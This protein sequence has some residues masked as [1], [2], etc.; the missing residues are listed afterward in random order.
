VS[1]LGERYGSF[2]G[3]TTVPA[4]QSDA[5][6]RSLEAA[7][8]EF[9]HLTKL[10]DRSLTEIETR[11]AL[12]LGQPILAYLRDPYFSETVSSDK[13]REFKAESPTHEEKLKQL[14]DEV[15]AL[16]GDGDSDGRGG[17]GGDIQPVALRHYLRPE[18]IGELVFEDIKRIIEEKYPAG[19]ELEPF[20]RERL[21]H[22]TRGRS[23]VN[24]SY[25]VSE[26][27]FLAIDTHVLG[28]D[29]R[30]DDDDGGGDADG[31]GRLSGSSSSSS[32][33][34]S[35]DRYADN[36]SE[37]SAFSESS[38]GA[39]EDAI[40]EREG[41]T[42]PLLVRG[43]PGCGKSALL[44]NWF[45]RYKGHR[46][47]DVVVA[48]WVGCSPAST[49]AG[50]IVA[51]LIREIREG[52]GAEHRDDARVPSLAEF[53][54]EELAAINPQRRR[55]VIV[56]DGLDRIDPRDD[57]MDLVWLPRFFPRSVRAVVSAGPSRALDV[58]AKRVAGS[59]GG[60][61]DSSG[62]GGGGGIG[63]GAEAATPSPPS[64]SSLTV[65]PLTPPHRRALLQTYLSQ[66]SKRLPPPTEFL[67][68]KAEQT[69]NPRYLVTL[70]DETILLGD[71]ASLTSTVA[72]YLEAQTTSELYAKVLKRMESDYDK[73]PAPPI[74]SLILTSLLTSRVGLHPS[75]ELRPLLERAGAGAGEGNWSDFLTVLESHGM[76][77]GFGQR[78]VLANEALREGVG[79]AFLSWTTASK[80]SGGGGGG[81]GG[82]SGSSVATS[83]SHADSVFTLCED[84]VITAAES[85][86]HAR[87]ADLFEGNEGEITRRKIEELPWHLELCGDASRLAGWLSSLAVF[88][89]MWTMGY[90]YDLQRYWRAIDKLIDQCRGIGGPPPSGA[91]NM[92]NVLRSDEQYLALV[93][94]SR[95]PPGVVVSDLLTRLAE[96]MAESSLFEASLGLFARA[97]VHYQNA[98]L[99]LGVAQ[100][101]TRVA[102]VLS[103]L[104][105]FDDAEAALRRSLAVYIKETGDEGIEVGRIF[106]SLG[107]VLSKSAAG[108]SANLAPARLQEARTCLDKSLEI[109]VARLGS[110]AEETADVLLAMGEL[111][112]M[113]NY[114]DVAL[115]RFKLA[116]AG[117]E[118]RLGDAHPRLVPTL[119]RLG[120]LYIELDEFETAESTLHTALAIATE[121]LGAQSRLTGEVLQTLA[122]LYE[123]QE[124]YSEA[125]AL[126]TRTLAIVQRVYGPQ[127]LHAGRMLLQ[128]GVVE[129]EL[130]RRSEGFVKLPTTSSAWAYVA[131][132]LHDT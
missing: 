88:D 66:R 11:T 98:F 22:A 27:L 111:D 79:I 61:H 15:E 69:S 68:A 20:E 91:P 2:P 39:S 55:V 101:D 102:R 1:F 73:A 48:H 116:L 14:R 94:A 62:G 129:A 82:S 18:Q 97:R 59:A 12:R 31:D 36:L 78:A 9:P 23:L 83:L 126:L 17:G 63:I 117:L 44:A 90:R 29:G 118:Q 119:A 45:S 115:G 75:L 107:C 74:V 131:G 110:A 128:L 112:A 71:H 26:D 93:K 41:S 13:R 16:G 103:E 24:S 42:R 64:A 19:M 65:P 120:S 95:F 10:R 106:W 34:S 86:A 38:A 122:C 96:F 72:R 87:L 7:V 81:G 30:D 99:P 40:A 77:E 53:F 37:S 130:S 84:R 8:P 89:A 28:S 80:P 70:L 123:M 6:R 132:C 76:I 47:E 54:A 49:E 50:G 127:H 3:D 56:I 60:G 33:S 85:A 121:K 100:V 108:V 43:P 25:V 52:L 51:R 21:R 109:T 4:S 67:I 124:R 35:A 32:S 92:A 5:A 46:N 58:L 125:A 114:P 104:A 57:A 113:E 105:R